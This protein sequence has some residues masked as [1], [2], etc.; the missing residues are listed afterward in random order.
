MLAIG[1]KLSVWPIAGVVPL[2]K[3]SGAR[4][5]IVNAEPTEMDALAD[6]VI[7]GPI[8]GILPR[9]IGDAD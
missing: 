3:E 1:T 5:I 8:S 4:V 9:L 6:A 7:R 2:A